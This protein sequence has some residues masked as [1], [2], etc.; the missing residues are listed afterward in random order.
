MLM[1]EPLDTET[2]SFYLN[3]TKQIFENSEAKSLISAAINLVGVLSEVNAKFNYSMG[4]FQ[5]LVGKIIVIFQ[6]NILTLFSDE[7]GSDKSIKNLLSKQK[8]YISVL[9]TYAKL[10]KNVEHLEGNALEV[11]S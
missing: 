4:F 2:F 6:Q 10:V 5:N 1:Q 3:T 8:D 9:G 11:I 7:S